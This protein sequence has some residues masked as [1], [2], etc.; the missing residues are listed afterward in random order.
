[1]VFISTDIIN[2]YFGR[3]GVGKITLLTSLLI[4]YAFGLVWL[5]IQ[6]PPAEFWVALNQEAYGKYFDVNQS[7]QVVFTQSMGIIIGSLSAFL[8]AQFVDVLA[9]QKLRKITGSQKIWLRATGS[10]LISQLIDSFVVLIIAFYLFGNWDLS[11]V[12]AVAIV[13]YIYKFFVAVGLTPLLYLAH[14]LI[15]SYL[16]KDVAKEMTKEASQSS[17]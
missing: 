11:M 7:F 17:F 15:D 5:I 3:A 4:L 12:F 14:Y 1:M 13:N 10:T 8:V 2:E 6:L 9:F 16:G